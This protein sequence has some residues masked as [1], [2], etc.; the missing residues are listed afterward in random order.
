[1]FFSELRQAQTIEQYRQNCLNC[2][3]KRSGQNC[4]PK[5]SNELIEE[6][7]QF[8]RFPRELKHGQRSCVASERALA[9]AV[10]RRIGYYWLNSTKIE[11]LNSGHV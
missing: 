10:K 11:Q 6:A 2:L 8:P 1:M 7:K 4:I 5:L 3:V 9:S